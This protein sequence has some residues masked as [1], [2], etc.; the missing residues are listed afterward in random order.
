MARFEAVI[1][2]KLDAVLATYQSGS[3]FT[4]TAHGLFQKNHLV[5]LAVSCGVSCY[6]T[7]VAKDIMATC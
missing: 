6:G 1:T 4:L 2:K 3:L 7:R 5:V